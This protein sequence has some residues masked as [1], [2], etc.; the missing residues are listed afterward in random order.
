MT[1]KETSNDLTNMD[2]DTLRHNLLTVIRNLSKR[3]QT[4]RQMNVSKERMKE[5]LML[6]AGENWKKSRLAFVISAII[7]SIYDIKSC[8]KNILQ[9]IDEACQVIACL[10][11]VPYVT[12]TTINISKLH[13]YM[14]LTG[15][16]SQARFVKQR[17]ELWKEFRSSAVVTGSTLYDALGLRSLKNQTA[18]FDQVVSHIQKPEPTEQVKTMMKHGSENEI[19]ATATIA[20]KVLPVLNPEVKLYEE[21]C[22]PFA[23]NGVPTVVSPDGSCRCGIDTPPTHGVEIKCPFPGNKYSTPVS[24]NIAK[25]YVP[26]V[27]SEMFA[28]GAEKL[29]YVSYSSES[30]AVHEVEFDQSLWNDIETEV[31]HIYGS[32]KPTRPARKSENIPIIQ[33]K[34]DEFVK[35]KSTFLIE[36]PSV[37]AADCQHCSVEI[38]TGD[39][40][41]C[42][43]S[44][45]ESNHETNTELKSVLEI[46]Y[47][48]EQATKQSYQLTRHKASEFLGF[49]ISDTDR[50]F[51]PELLHSVPIAYGL[52]G[53]S[54]PTSILRTM[55]EDVLH[56]CAKQGLYVPICS[57]DGQWSRIAVRDRNDKPLTVLQLQKD[58]FHDAKQLSKSELIRKMSNCN[59]VEAESLDGLL[60]VAD[61]TWE[62]RA[63]MTTNEIENYIEVKGKKG[64]SVYKI[65]KQTHELIK[66]NV[67]TCINNE[68]PDIGVEDNI[69]NTIADSVVDQISPEI[70]EDINSLSNSHANFSSMTPVTNNGING[71]CESNS[72]HVDE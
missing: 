59:I 7:T 31:K 47:N 71:E 40:T 39:S 19:H 35:S 36:V 15:L 26:Q 10:N 45:V 9:I 46:L 13:N 29:Y 70:A 66:K 12:D 44:S 33:E 64:E 20:G 5:K 50:N 43:N 21:G 55:I 1:K 52:K 34:L 48:A 32:A 42:M 18:H 25:Y 24:Y 27:L 14:H 11:G 3:V 57:F 23:V 38:E 8:I 65:S 6:Q 4:L 37:R 54:L 16:S 63:N 62:K 22:Y 49:M 68:I 30:T 51:H 53:Y 58:V 56:A 2:K 60:N 61:V 17:S 69:L 67:Q 72:M 41:F 28:L